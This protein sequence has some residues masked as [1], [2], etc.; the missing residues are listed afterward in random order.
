M[1]LGKYIFLD[2]INYVQKLLIKLI[3]KKIEFENGHI[4]YLL[5]D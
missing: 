5:K 3:G 2:F 4:K 1:L